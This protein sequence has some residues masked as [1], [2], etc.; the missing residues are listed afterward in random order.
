MS[1]ERDILDLQATVARL[2]ASLG[3]PLAQMSISAVGEMYSAA[4]PA[5]FATNWLALPLPDAASTFVYYTLFLPPGWSGRTLTM[6]VM[7]APSSTNTGNVLWQFITK[8]LIAGTTTT[9]GVTTSSTATSA[10]PGTT[11]MP[12]LVSATATLAGVV[13]GDAVQVRIARVGGD[14]ADTFTGTANFIALLLSV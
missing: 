14:A 8:D 7:W 10:G 9:S 2:E 6:K 12:V 11:D 4:T 5:A 3:G 1:Q 13:T